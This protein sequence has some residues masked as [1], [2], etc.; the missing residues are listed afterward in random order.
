MSQREEEIS[1][2]FYLGRNDGLEVIALFI[3]QNQAR[4][5]NYQIQ[6]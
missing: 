3:A 6:A 4:L 5:K 1:T 2:D